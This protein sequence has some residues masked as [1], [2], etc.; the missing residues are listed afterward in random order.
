MRKTLWGVGVLSLLLAGTAAGYGIWQSGSEDPACQRAD[1]AKA[2]LYVAAQ[3]LVMC[4]QQPG[5]HDGCGNF[6]RDTRSAGDSYSTA[7]SYSAAQRCD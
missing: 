6:V 4:V 5:H 3:N 2:A 7:V 1:K